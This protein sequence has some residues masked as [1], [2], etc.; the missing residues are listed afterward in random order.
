MELDAAVKVAMTEIRQV[1]RKIA[2]AG[3]GP[4]GS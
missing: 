2:D 1:L 3:D 4:R